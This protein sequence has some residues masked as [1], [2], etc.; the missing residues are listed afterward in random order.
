MINIDREKV[1][2]AAIRQVIIQEDPGVG[3]DAAIDEVLRQLAPII[4][5]ATEIE[6]VAQRIVENAPKDI[7]LTY[8]L[9][10]DLRKMLSA[11]PY[12]AMKGDANNG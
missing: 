6:A 11:P 3:I 2:R 9:I 1:R 5:R 7:T 8:S 12:V 4:A 10:E